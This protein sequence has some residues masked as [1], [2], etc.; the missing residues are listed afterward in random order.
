MF[1][2]NFCIFFLLVALFSYVIYVKNEILCA[3]CIVMMTILF[4]K[5]INTVI[6]FK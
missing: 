6:F 4:Y 1:S 5:S 2:S 3:L